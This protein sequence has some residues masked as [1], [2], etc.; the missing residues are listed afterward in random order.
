MQETKQD[1]P[2][3]KKKFNKVTTEYINRVKAGEFETLYINEDGFI[4]VK[5]EKLRAEIAE[6]AERIR[7]KPTTLF[8]S[9]DYL[10]QEGLFK[11]KLVSKKELKTHYGKVLLFK[12][13]SDL[14]NPDSKFDPDKLYKAGLFYGGITYTEDDTLPDIELM[15]TLI[16]PE[17]EC[18]IRL[19][20]N[21]KGDKFYIRYIEARGH[22]VGRKEEDD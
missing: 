10:H 17:D 1:R 22:R 11:I 16:E 19:S 6:L 13:I 18:I 9:A 21:Y 4:D 7:N 8:D 2:K 15:A 5:D 3:A 20:K 12:I 14:D